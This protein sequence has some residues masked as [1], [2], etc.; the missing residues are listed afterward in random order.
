MAENQGGG[1]GVQDRVGGAYGADNASGDKAAAR[2]LSEAVEALVTLKGR[3]NVRPE[4][5]RELQASI[6]RLMDEA[7]GATYGV[8]DL[9]PKGP[10]WWCVALNGSDMDVSMARY[11]R[12]VRSD[13]RERMRFRG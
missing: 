11:I 9:P 4:R 5:V 7:P 2:D 13:L 3:Q 12:E 8:G 6:H 1:T 10:A